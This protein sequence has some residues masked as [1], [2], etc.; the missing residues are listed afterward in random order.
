[1]KRFM[2]ALAALALASRAAAIVTPIVP[3]NY[4]VV[5]A[6]LA[7]PTGRPIVRNSGQ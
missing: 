1:M 7:I 4:S 3:A 2:L 5:T 6:P